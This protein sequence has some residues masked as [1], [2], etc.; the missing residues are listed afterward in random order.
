MLRARFALP[1]LSNYLSFTAPLFK[2][3]NASAAAGTHRSG[4]CPQF[5]LD[6]TFI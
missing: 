4:M 6:I 1:P 3:S 5:E 2:R